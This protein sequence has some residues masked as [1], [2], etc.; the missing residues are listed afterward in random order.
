MSVIVADYPLKS[1]IERSATGKHP[2]VKH[3][4]KTYSFD[5]TL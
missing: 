4:L 2:H 5:L 1:I 3:N